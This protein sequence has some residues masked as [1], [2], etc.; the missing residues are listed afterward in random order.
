MKPGVLVHH[1]FYSKGRQT[2][3]SLNKNP[4]LWENGAGEDKDRRRQSCFYRIEKDR[5]GLRII[6]WDL[7]SLIQSAAFKSF[8]KDVWKLNKRGSD[9]ANVNFQVLINLQ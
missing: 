2:Q 5:S 4:V 3:N 8:L 9:D 7:V 1:C 6:T